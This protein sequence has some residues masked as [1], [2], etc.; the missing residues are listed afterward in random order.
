MTDT[1]PSIDKQ[2]KLYI[3]VLVAL[4]AFT[5]ITV[6]ASRISASLSTHVAVALTI[7]AIKG[8]LVAAIFMHLKWEKAVTLWSVLLLCAVFFVFLI[9]LPTLIAGDLPPGVRS[10]TWG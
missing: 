5:I 10:G 3:A 7:S 4:A 1:H 9:A 6:L 8:T 2:V